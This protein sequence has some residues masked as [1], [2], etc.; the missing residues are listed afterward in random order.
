MYTEYLRKI[1]WFFYHFSLSKQK[2]R[3]SKIM[4]QNQ[5]IQNESIGTNILTK[6]RMYRGSLEGGIYEK[7]KQDILALKYEKEIKNNKGMPRTHNA[8]T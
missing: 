2:S 5:E 1:Q 7:K 8:T 4:T 3:V 6:F